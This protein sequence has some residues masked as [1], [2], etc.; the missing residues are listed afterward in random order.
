MSHTYKAEGCRIHVRQKDVLISRC[1]PKEQ[2]ACACAFGMRLLASP[3]CRSP[4][5]WFGLDTMPMSLSP[6]Q[7]GGRVEGGSPA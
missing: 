2:A 5:S 6:H 3:N 4:Q 1:S 7:K